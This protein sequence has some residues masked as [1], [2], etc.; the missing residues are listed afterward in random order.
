[1]T[2]SYEQI[3]KQIESLQ[4]QAEKL[5]AREVDEVI[6]RIKVAI[7]H[8][9]LSA[10]QLGFGAAADGVK[11]KATKEAPV[12]AAKYSDGQGNTWSGMGK[13]PGWLRNA[14]EAG[15]TLEEFSTQGP[16]SETGGGK[17]KSAKKRKAKIAYK[18]DAG[19]SWSGMGPK[20]RWLKEA[21]DAGKTLEQMQA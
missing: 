10:A 9:G 3:Q 17:R 15:R 14:L 12:R 7:K 4:R 16:S 19:H 6:A 2:Q 11:R 20:P 5:R 8:Y 18:D 21:L 1:M 13:R